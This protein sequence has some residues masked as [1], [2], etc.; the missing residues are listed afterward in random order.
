MTWHD[1]RRCSYATQVPFAVSSLR[2]E[3]MRAFYG[4][5]CHMLA[6]LRP[7][8]IVCCICFAYSDRYDARRNVHD[9]DYHMRLSDA[10][11]A[12]SLI[13]AAHF[14]DWRD[15]G[16]AYRF[17]DASYPAPNRSLASEVTGQV[18]A[19]RDRSGKELGRQA[20]G[21]AIMPVHA[22]CLFTTD[23]CVTRRWLGRCCAAGSGPTWSTVRTT[24]SAPG[25]S[26][27]MRRACCAR[28]TKST[29]SPRRRWPST[30][31]RYAD[32]A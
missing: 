24:R 9:Y 5:A 32:V 12:P 16:L 15:T 10:G 17:R 20:R 25:W 2:D 21:C 31:S 30:T 18:V 26:R 6:A 4:C 7:R 1:M 22:P 28:A 23:D 8:L 27:R 11:A 13:H 19:A 29:S 3:R 14:R